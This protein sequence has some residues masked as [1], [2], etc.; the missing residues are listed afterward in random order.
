[1]ETIYELK[2]M[3]TTLWQQLLASLRIRVYLINK[4]DFWL[5]SEWDFKLTSPHFP[6]LMTSTLLT[7]ECI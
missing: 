1:M 6:R 5:K 3:D 2:R 7:F 4:L